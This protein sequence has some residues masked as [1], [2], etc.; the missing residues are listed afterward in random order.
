MPAGLSVGI[1]I[2]ALD[3]GPD[4]YPEPDQ[5][6]PERFLGRDYGPFEHL[7][8]GGGA[9]RGVGAA[10]AVYEMKLVLATVLR[11]YAL[12]FTDP[13]D[14]RSALRNIMVSPAKKIKMIRV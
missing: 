13:T 14:V 12:Q 10:F 2:V 9:R 1:K 4:L 3:R 6:H 11:A 5:F 8:F 7:S